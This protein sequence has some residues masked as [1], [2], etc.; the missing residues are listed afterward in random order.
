[1]V[2]ILATKDILVR[3]L[4]SMAT[5]DLLLLLNAATRVDDMELMPLPPP[6]A[7][8]VLRGPC[9]PFLLLTALPDLAERSRPLLLSPPR[10]DS[11]KERL[12]GCMAG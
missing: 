12:S 5:E 10:I 2:V 6:R 3:V 11:R 7:A 4:S 1:L 9:D 8:D